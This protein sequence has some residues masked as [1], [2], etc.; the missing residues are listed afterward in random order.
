MQRWKPIAAATTAAGVL[1]LGGGVAYAAA[2]GAHPGAPRASGQ[3]AH[4]GPNGHRHRPL[5]RRVVHGTVTVRTRKGFRTIEVQ[6]GT[7]TAASPTRLTVTSPDKVTRTY[8]MNGGTRVRLN[9]QT[10]DRE[11]V[12][13]GQRAFVVTSPQDGTS[14][15]KRVVLRT[16]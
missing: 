14:V 2:T 9:R 15:A 4:A 1:V 11:H 5:L 3:S 7:V 16:R 12:A 6:R 13:K 10:S 8:T